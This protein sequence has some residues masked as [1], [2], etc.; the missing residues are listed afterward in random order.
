MIFV[1]NG[2]PISSID[3]M[4]V[5]AMYGM[6]IRGKNKCMNIVERH[7]DEILN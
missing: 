5:K 3:V 7:G 6:D 4:S 2:R 1:C